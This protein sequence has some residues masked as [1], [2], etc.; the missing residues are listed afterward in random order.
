MTSGLREDQ[1]CTLRRRHGKLRT[2]F[3]RR[4]GNQTSTNPGE[5]VG[6]IF[7]EVANPNQPGQD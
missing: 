6:K 5:P 1:P 3:Q 4:G 7:R 2:L